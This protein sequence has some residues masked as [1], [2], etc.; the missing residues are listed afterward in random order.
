[1]VL[2][3]SVERRSLPEADGSGSR[4]HDREAR[5]EPARA[6]P[7]S[8][9]WWADRAEAAGRRRPRAGGLSTERIILAALAVLREGGLEALTLRA[10]AQRL[11]TNGT[12]S[13][14]R[15]IASRDELMVL[16]IDHTL[17]EVRLDRTGQGWRA[18]IEA[19]M[20]E[21]RRVIL[22]QPVP[23]TATRSRSINGPNMLRIVD[24]ALGRFLDAGLTHKRAALATIT[25]IEFVGGA[26]DIQRSI[27]GRGP[28]GASGS[29][30]F[31]LLLEGLPPGQLT[32]LRTA[33]AD[34]VAASADDVFTSGMT[35][36]L[37]GVTR[38]L[39]SGH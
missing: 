13:L 29:A 22:E 38:Q 31:H 11:G 16:I 15:H 18:D 39:P 1:M 14:Y 34:Y 21:M 32:A 27:A 35:I 6:E 17:G 7:G 9:R 3:D 23:S 20:R 5:R 8:V 36:L 12:A 37:D 28:T 26:A 24:A 25:M 10:V 33:G 30:G 19:L 4:A 2:D